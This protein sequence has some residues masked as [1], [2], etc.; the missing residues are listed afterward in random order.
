MYLNMDYEIH[1][2]TKLDY[3]FFHTSRLFQASGMQLLKNQ[4]EQERTQI[5]TILMLFLDNPHLAGY[6]LIGN[7]SMFLKTDGS[8][9]WLHPGPLVRSPFHT[10]NQCYDRIPTLYEGQIQFV[11]PIKRQTHP[12]ATY[13]I[14]PTE[15]KTS[16]NLT[17]FKKTYGIH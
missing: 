4:C 6:M 10:M 12:A 17:W 1:L 5:N 2:G 3:F 9:V 16:S 8:L 7:K 11:D 14:V 15:S 13:K